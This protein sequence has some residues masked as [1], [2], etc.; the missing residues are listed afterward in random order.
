MSWHSCSVAGAALRTGP[1][2]EYLHGALT[3]TWTCSSYGHSIL[4][5]TRT[6]STHQGPLQGVQ[7][8]LI[9]AE[10]RG[11]GRGPQAGNHLLPLGAKRAAAR[12]CTCWPGVLHVEHS[13]GCIVAARTVKLKH[14]NLLRGCAC[15]TEVDCPSIHMSP[16]LLNLFLAQRSPTT[17]SAVSRSC[18]VYSCGIARIL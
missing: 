5:G 17:R 3:S 9:A 1:T 11:G 8:Q 18:K 7:E 6:S 14:I 15:H 2:H 13:V 4:L 10:Q 16:V 12:G